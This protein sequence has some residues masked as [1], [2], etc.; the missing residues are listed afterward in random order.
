MFNMYINPSDKKGVISPEI[1]GHFSEHL[2]RCIYDGI[3][4]GE[5]SDI[6]N[7]RGIRTDVVEAFKNIKMP[8][9]RWPGGCFADEYHWKDGIG[10][11]SGRKKMVNTNWGGVTEDNSFGTHEF[12][13]LCEQVGCEPYIAGNLGSGSVEELSQWVEYMTFDGVS[14]MADLRRKNG[15]EKPWKVKYLGI[16]N[17]NWGCGGNMCPQFYANVYKRFQSFCHDFGDNKLFKVA[18]GPAG[19]DYEWTETLM[20]NLKPNHTKAISLHYYTYVDGWDKKGSATDFSERDYY[21]TM[22]ES[23]FIDELVTRHGQIMDR[24]DPEKKI[25]LFVDEWGSWYDVLEGT[26]PGFLYQQNTVRDAI[27]AA[28]FLNVFNNHCDR[29]KMA[30]IAQVVNVLQAI[31]LT[32]GEKMIKTPTYHVFDLFKE[33]HG[34][35]L[36]YSYSDNKKISEFEVPMLSYSASIKDDSIVVTIA[37][38]SLSE[39]ANISISVADRPVTQVSGR[40]VTQE[41]HRY[42]DFDNPDNVTITGL[43][44]NAAGGKANAL[45]PACSVTEL[46]IK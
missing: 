1:Y 22:K 14:P 36:V 23:F 15:R 31:I 44:V 37:N 9:L 32:E 11:K 13:D 16:G 45:L 18:C 43:E 41:V 21:K 26:N 33:H 35:E 25:A 10:E 30:N 28:V 2:G 12:M 4:V 40:I 19:D 34:A 39:D 7:V 20:K 24:Y 29:V 3:Y 38:C 27:E 6:P 17:E 8:V 5:D 46:I 42:N